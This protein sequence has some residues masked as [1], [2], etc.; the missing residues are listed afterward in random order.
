MS[1]T[2]ELRHVDSGW[3]MAA[4]APDALSV[5]LRGDDQVTSRYDWLFPFLQLY[6][7]LSLR[8]E[9]T[10]IRYAVVEVDQG[11]HI[12]DNPPI[13]TKTAYPTTYE[14]AL[15]EVSTFLAEIFNHLDTTS[16]PNEQDK[17]ELWLN[18]KLNE[19]TVAEIH[20]QV[21]EQ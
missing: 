16:E 6:E 15:A 20:A 2:L 21:S 19:M 7:A 4:N 1:F 13:A 14:A 12:V 9:R 10:N 18:S 8:D 5:T 11:I 17:A 3:W